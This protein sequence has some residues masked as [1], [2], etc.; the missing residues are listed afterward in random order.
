MA[1]YRCTRLEMAITGWEWLEIVGMDGIGW[2][3]LEMAR[4]DLK[5]LEMKG[6]VGKG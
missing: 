3:G 4:P 1:A 5:C 2:K 6:M